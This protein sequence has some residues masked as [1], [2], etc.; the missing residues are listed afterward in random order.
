MYTENLWYQNLF[1]LIVSIQK[2]LYLY[3]CIYF[4]GFQILND[5][6]VNRNAYLTSE[7]V[8]IWSDVTETQKITQNYNCVCMSVLRRSK[9]WQTS[10][11]TPVCAWRMRWTSTGRWWTNWDRTGTSSRKKRKPCKRW[12]VLFYAVRHMHI[13]GCL[14]YCSLCFF[15]VPLLSLTAIMLAHTSTPTKYCTGIM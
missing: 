4:V 8:L 9:G 3:K 6:T 14:L 2:C 7:C 13:V 11:R 15:S 5:F 1:C 12:E 10:W